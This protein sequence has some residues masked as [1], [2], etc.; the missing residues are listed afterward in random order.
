MLRS[1]L[2]PAALF[3]G[4]AGFGLCSITYGRAMT[5]A[6][7]AAAAPLAA[8]F[9]LCAAAAAASFAMGTAAVCDAA[10]KRSRSRLS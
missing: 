6:P 1:F 2:A 5:S 9:A 4:F 7:S 8:P 10:E 3:W